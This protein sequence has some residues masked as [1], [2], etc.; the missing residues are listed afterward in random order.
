MLADVSRA[1]ATRLLDAGAVRVAGQVVTVGRSSVLAGVSLEVRRGPPSRSRPAADPTVEFTVV[2]ADDD[3]IVLEKPAELVVHPGAGRLDGTLVSGLL[4][5][6]EDLEATFADVCPAERPGIVHRLDR[7]TSGLLM[8]ARSIPAYFALVG[9]LSRRDVHRRYRAL[10]HGRMADDR[11]IVDAP[12]A[13]S[14]RT[15]TRMAV[16]ADG[17]E[18]RTRY[19]VL[20]RF[21]TSDGVTFPA[22]FLALALET[23]RTHQI[24]VHLAAIGHPVIGDE[25][26]RSG[27]ATPRRLPTGR[28]FLHAAELGFEHPTTGETMRF[29]SPLP[30]DLT[31]ELE[32]RH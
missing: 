24:R 27:A 21:E 26:Y 32:R 30:A 9:Q 17:R 16:R 8:V 7:G 5:R 31:Q 4:A 2:H 12:I 20:E 3:V 19:T 15:P 6:F 11:G 10:V 14:I 25:R 18:A 22:T 1:E 28:M 29:E 23:G 13:R